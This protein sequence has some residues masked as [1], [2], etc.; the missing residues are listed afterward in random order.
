MINSLS[1]WDLCVNSVFMC[2]IVSCGIINLDLVTLICW[3]LATCG[4]VSHN[5]EWSHVSYN[6]IADS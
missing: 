3:E 1:F 4:P 2:A 5:S 6:V